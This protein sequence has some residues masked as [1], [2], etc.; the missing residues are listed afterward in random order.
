MKL[1]LFLEHWTVISHCSAC[2]SACGCAHTG[3]RVCSCLCAPV[4]SG[5]HTCKVWPVAGWRP[6]CCQEKRDEFLWSLLSLW[7]GPPFTVSFCS[8]PTAT[9]T[10][11][12]PLPATDDLA[13]PRSATAQL[14]FLSIFYGVVARGCVCARVYR[15]TKCT[16]FHHFPPFLHAMI[17]INFAGFI[18]LNLRSKYMQY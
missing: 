4:C 17:C 10:H 14:Q 1:P 12:S 16:T 3:A 7:C 13:D 15:N 2:A 18:K 5:V 9:H 6:R 8:E 11:I